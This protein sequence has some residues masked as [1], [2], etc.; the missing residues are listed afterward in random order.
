MSDNHA[1]DRSRLSARLRATT[2]LLEEITRDRGMLAALTIDERTRLLNAAGDVY[3]PDVALRRQRAKAKQR[4][5][6]A[7]KVRRSQTVLADTGIRALRSKPVFTTPNV[8]PSDPLLL[9]DGASDDAAPDDQSEREVLLAQHC[10]VC[11]QKYAAI[12]HFYDQLCPSCGEFNYRK[13]TETADLHGRV[14]LL[15]GGR[16]KIGYQAGIKLLRAGA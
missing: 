11:K 13:R 6:K 15:T 16:V 9:D 10:Y 3:C 8:F 12:H 4:E 7:D 14:A 2:E 1:D 5:D